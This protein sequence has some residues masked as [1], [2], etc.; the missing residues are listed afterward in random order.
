MAE[1][2]PAA[3]GVKMMISVPNFGCGGGLAKIET[4]RVEMGKLI[5]LIAASMVAA[6]AALSALV[7]TLRERLVSVYQFAIERSKRSGGN[8]SRG[9]FLTG[10]HRVTGK[11]FWCAWGD[12]TLDRSVGFDTV[13]LWVAAIRAD[14]RLPFFWHHRSLALCWAV[15]PDQSWHRCPVRMVSSHPVRRD[16]QFSDLLFHG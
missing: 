4:K 7:G 6:P 2:Q 14:R 5:L 3:P 12:A 15:L 9:R 10:T 8:L 1:N 16:D 11:T 13:W